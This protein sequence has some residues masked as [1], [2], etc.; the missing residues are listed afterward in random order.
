MPDVSKLKQTIKDRTGLS[1]RHLNR[2]ISE[3]AKND[4]LSRPVAIL[5]VARDRGISIDRFASEEDLAQ[6][7]NSTRPSSGTS[8]APAPTQ[9]AVPAAPKRA[10]SR[11]Q[12]QRRP[13][14]P[15][16]R[17]KV[18]VVHGRNEQ[19]RKDTFTFLRSIGLQPLEWHKGIEATNVGSPS[20]KQILDAMFDQAAAVVVLLTPDDT[21]RLKP[22]LQSRSDPAHEKKFVGQARP[23]VLF[24]AGMA[25]GS[26]PDSVV[27]VQVGWVKPFTDI[28]GIHVTHM[29]NTPQKRS[30]L[31]T[32]LKGVGCDVDTG[33]SDWYST[34]NFETDE[35]KGAP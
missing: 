30:E 11:T 26:H 1:D 22:E 16:S 32:K 23:N 27:L 17:K 10:A 29:D 5:A 15:K 6:L 21:T 33:G 28:G 19:L 3:R 9:Q 7:R 25:F 34:G 18:F 14:A 13:T 4:L 24:E 35:K 20:I 8:T 31:A 12:G 2:L